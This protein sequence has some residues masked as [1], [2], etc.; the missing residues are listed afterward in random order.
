M[1]GFFRIARA[2]RIVRVLRTVR[3][4][5][6]LR[7]LISGIFATLASSFWAL[8]ILALIIYVFSIA[9]TEAA[10]RY[11]YGGSSCTGAWSADDHCAN[12]HYFFGSLQQSCLTLF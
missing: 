12:V 1:L 9:F 4:L 6:Q 11:L 8:T 5:K 3:H 2:M 10:T 7:H